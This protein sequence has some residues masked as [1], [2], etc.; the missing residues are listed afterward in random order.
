MK[1][2]QIA[3]SQQLQL[4]QR[5]CVKQGIPYELNGLSA[6]VASSGGDIRFTLNTMQSLVLSHGTVTVKAVKSSLLNSK[7]VVQSMDDYYNLLFICRRSH[8]SISFA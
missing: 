5:I 6:I 1:L 2:P 3:D 7:D 8:G 4:L